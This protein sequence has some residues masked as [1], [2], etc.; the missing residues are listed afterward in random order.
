MQGDG[1]AKRVKILKV[2]FASRI[3]L[4]LI[5]AAQM[6]LPPGK[7]LEVQNEQ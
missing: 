7:Q 6:F 4:L 1:A 2:T 5:A 3:Y